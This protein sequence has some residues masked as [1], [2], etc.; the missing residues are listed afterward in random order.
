VYRAADAGKAGRDVSVTRAGF[1]YPNAPIAE[2]VFD[3]RVEE[4]S[5]EQLARVAA[6][7]DADYPKREETVLTGAELQSGPLGVTTKATRHMNGFRYTS[8]DGLQIV[9]MRNDGFT[10]SRL[11]PYEEWAIFHVEARRLLGAYVE[12]G[13]P[14]FLTRLALRYINQVKVP[15]GHVQ[16]D[17]YLRTRPEISND[18]PTATSGYFMTVD[19]PLPFFGSAVRIT[20][21]ILP[22]DVLPRTWFSKRPSPTRLGSCSNDDH[23]DSPSTRVVHAVNERARL[24][25]HRTTH[26]CDSC[27]NSTS[28][29]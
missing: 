28:P 24:R 16:I 18:M 26:E 1:R 9:Q 12:L 15:A 11:A 4:L 17:E 10:F 2:A 13:T 20:Q 6:F 7:T 23:D 8:Q 5:D 19:I 25:R 27:T 29:G 21:T 14:S 22:S 3:I